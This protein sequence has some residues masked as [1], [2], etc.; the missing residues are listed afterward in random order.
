MPCSGSVG[1]YGWANGPLVGF[2]LET[3]GLDRERDEPV[4]FAFVQFAGGEPVGVEEGFLLP[5]RAISRGAAGVHK[6]SEQR[7]AD[8]GA[9]P[10]ADGVRRI[11][12][13]LAALGAEGVPLVGCNLAYDLTIVD[14]VLSRGSPPTSLR[15]SWTGPALD[16]LVL[17]RALDAD[18]AA[19]PVR[20]LEA[21]CAHYGLASPTHTARGDAEAAV[22]VL[23]AQAERFGRLGL[24][25]LAALQRRQAEWHAA[26]CDG[27][28]VRRRA[29][30]RAVLVAYDSAW[31]YVARDTLF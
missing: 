22:R 26:W 3:T 16:V 15:S 25:T 4:S 23:L 30:G 19:R 1:R 31:P 12:A 9:L 20:R 24:M 11:V 18:F 21:L 13:R 27:A 28:S 2:D 29:Q 10:L 8:L 6:L 17:D 5:R 7:L 14:R